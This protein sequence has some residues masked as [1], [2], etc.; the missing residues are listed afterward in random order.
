MPV[1]KEHNVLILPKQLQELKYISL[2][3]P[4]SVKPHRDHLY[5]TYGLHHFTQFSTYKDYA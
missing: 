3:G 5:I 1:Q 4:F 2:L